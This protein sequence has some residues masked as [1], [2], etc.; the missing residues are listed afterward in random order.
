[1]Q[2]TLGTLPNLE[3]FCLTFET[4]SFTRAA[5]KLGLTP[6]AT[7]RAVA[8]LEAALGVTLFRRTTRSLAPTDEARRYYAACHSALATLDEA[9]REL[10]QGQRAPR[11]EVRISMP[12]TY[13][14]HRLLPSLGRFRER[15]PDIQVVAHVSNRNVDFVRDG[16]ELAVRMGTHAD[17]TVVRRS[18][19][20]FSLGLFASPRYLAR[21]PAPTTVG[22]LAAHLGIAFVM[23]S[24]GRT[25]PWEI[26]DEG[27]R[28]AL[29]PPNPYRVSG[30]VLG[31]IALAVAGVGV[32][33]TYDFLVERER[34]AGE[35]VEVLPH[36]RGATRPFALLYPSA[37]KLSRPARLL[38]DFVVSEARA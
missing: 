26:I 18:L 17:P 28:R 38:A 29:P 36:L 27:I 32:V 13:G 19:G 31:A 22:E 30:D 1:M 15:F 8:R 33:Q 11:G 6:Q 9:E 12:T 21:R 25:L 7:S 5:E 16:F 37:R 35:L 4:G 10:S 23:P 3:V 20:D 34:A 24:S 2:R 14:S